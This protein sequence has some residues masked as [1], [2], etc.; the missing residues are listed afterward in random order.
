[1]TEL[2]N[3]VQPPVN[4]ADLISLAEAADHCKYSQEYLSLRARQ[5]KL[6]SIKRGRNWFTTLG[7]LDDYLDQ[8]DDVKTQLKTIVAIPSPIQELD[9]VQ[10]SA[11]TELSGPIKTPINNLIEARLPSPATEPA[12]SIDP[13]F[14]VQPLAVRRPDQDARFAP[15]DVELIAEPVAVRTGRHFFWDH[16]DEEPVLPA[17]HEAIISRL[18]RKVDEVMSREGATPVIIDEAEER[19]NFAEIDLAE[20][21]VGDKFVGGSSSPA[22]IAQSL[23]KPSPV[24]VDQPI[25]AHLQPIIRPTLIMAIVILFFS[26]LVIFNKP[27]RISESIA[28]GAGLTIYEL[29]QRLIEAGEAQELAKQSRLANRANVIQ[30]SELTFPQ[31]Q[32]AG[33]SIIRADDLSPNRVIRFFQIVEIG[34]HTVINSLSN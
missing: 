20:T 7:W 2:S 9:P 4:K 25:V 8:V 21:V 17:S 19:P 33:S 24:M 6:R 29:G 26:G 27:Y 3:L 12:I 32:V 14:V 18:Q 13:E 16:S 15:T 28:V 34:F 10:Y 23:A 11:T 30:A 1:M 22:A 5:G 31:G